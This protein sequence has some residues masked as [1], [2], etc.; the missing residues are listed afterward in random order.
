MRPN[1]LLTLSVPDRFKSVTNT[2]HEVRFLLHD[3]FEQIDEFEEDSDNDRIIVFA[4]SRML[5]VLQTASTWMLYR[6][7]KVAPLLLFQLY[8]HHAIRGSHVFPCVYAL[9]S[10]KATNTYKRVF[11][12]LKGAR[13]DIN[14]QI[15]VTDL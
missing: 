10:K 7:F 1:P 11:Q 8:T 9:P 14:P 6:T 2:G 12:I 13:N 3:D 4:S 5:H 15:C